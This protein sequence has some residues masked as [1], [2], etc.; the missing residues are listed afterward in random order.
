MKN[1][2]V[3]KDIKCILNLDLWPPHGWPCVSAWSI[4]LLKTVSMFC[5]ELK[6]VQNKKD[7]KNMRYPTKKQS[8]SEEKDWFFVGNLEF[9]WPFLFWN[10]FSKKLKKHDNFID[11]N[12]DAYDRTRQARYCETV[13]KRHPM[14]PLGWPVGVNITLVSLKSL[15]CWFNYPFVLIYRLKSLSS[16]FW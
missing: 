5:H 3:V 8:F 15:D 10:D 13:Q 2:T 4:Q 14:A 6:L 16:G 12:L 11:K 1:Y 7:Q 9:F